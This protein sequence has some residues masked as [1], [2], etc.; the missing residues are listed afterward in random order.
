MGTPP[1][2]KVSIEPEHLDLISRIYDLP[3]HPERWTAVL[4]EFSA[5]LNAGG[6]GFGIHDPYA[7][8]F[9][10]SAVTTSFGPDFQEQYQRAM[11]PGYQ[12]PFAKLAINPKRGFVRDLDLL[13]LHNV[14]QY[15]QRP[16]I[17]WTDRHF[18][19]VFG[20]ASSLN[21]DRAWVDVLYVMFSR[22]HG[23]MTR[24]ETAVGNL[25]LDHFAK[26][27]ELCRSFG[28][29]QSRFS[30]V[31]EALDRFH[32]G[33]FILTPS[34]AVVVQNAEATRIV[35][36][37]DGLSLKRDGHLSPD[38]DDKR[39]QLKAAIDLATRTSRAQEARSESLL[40]LPRRSGEE[41]YLL[42]ISPMRDDGAIEADFRGCLI[43][44]IDPA[45]TDT[46]TTKGMR[47]LYN[48]TET[49]ADVCRLVAQGHDT[50]AMADARNVTRETVRGYI[51]QVLHKTGV[52]NRAQ[53]VRLALKVNLPIDSVSDDA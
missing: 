35:E 1:S 12:S 49:E 2:Q 36:A 24:Q 22:E 4:D 32:I 11:P 21:V 29:L 25:F 43:F 8:E 53:L 18:N 44:A 47:E 46:V 52:G 40:S 16:L 31:L 26:A 41:P 15:T 17:K 13:D 3:L 19:V 37:T 10:A 28:V 45:R 38:D 42:E 34:G 30:G 33:V 50:D 14:E 23:P 20:A 5:I 39:H 27:T 48:L 9:Q 51:K 7:V 6:A